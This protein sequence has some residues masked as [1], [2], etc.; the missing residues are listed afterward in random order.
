MARKAARVLTD[1][2]LQIMGVLWS[3]D[4]VSVEQIQDRLEDEGKSLALPSIRT[5]LKILQEKKYVAR[6]ALGRKH[7]YR[8]CVSQKSSQMELVK[9]LVK[10]AFNGSTRDLLELLGEKSEK[11]KKKRKKK[12]EKKKSKAEKVAA[13]V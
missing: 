4:E 5:M 3:S 2:E 7:I 10:R 8:P 12:K 13:H 11:K 9:D 6:R 1:L